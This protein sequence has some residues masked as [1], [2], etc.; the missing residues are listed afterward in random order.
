MGAKKWDLL[1]DVKEV[2]DEIRQPM[3]RVAVLTK[4][5]R[6]LLLNSITKKWHSSRHGA[7][8]VRDEM[9]A[10]KLKVHGAHKALYK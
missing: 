1:R 5:C 7:K 4:H 6:D 3:S 10:T 8:E 2:K 9:R